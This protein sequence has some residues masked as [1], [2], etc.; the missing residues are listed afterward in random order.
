MSWSDVKGRIAANWQSGVTV[1]LVSI[2]L[3][4]SLAVASQATPVMGIIT[5][6]WAG[7]MAAIFGGSH[8]N[9][10]G[11]TGA[12]SGLLA[13]Y[14][15][16]HGMQM[17]PMLAIVTGVF[18]LIAYV[19]RLERFLV[20]VPASAI[21]GFTLGVAFIIGLNQLN[22]ALGLSGLPSH[23]TFIQNVLESL[24]HIGSASSVTVLVFLGFLAALFAFVK[25]LPKVPGAIVLAPIGILLGYASQTGMLPL[26][27]Q[28]LGARYPDMSAK[29]FALPTFSF[30][31]SLI[32]AA[33]GVAL[34][35]IL[36][37]MISAKIADG[38]TKTKYN[39]RK[40]M[41]GLGIANVASGLAGGIPATAALARTSLN[42]KTKATHST[43]AAI[44][45]VSIAL[46]SLILLT[47]FVY[48]PLAVIAAILVFVAARMVEGD[49]FK[50]FYR[51]DRKSF[52]IALLV[53][54]ITVY[55][56]PIVGLLLGTVVSLLLFMERLSR[57]QFDLVV[58][59]KDRG[60]VKKIVSEE[61]VPIL[62]GSSDTLV[63]S[64]KGQLAYIN[65][66]SHIT[67]FQQGLGGYERVLL[68]L[69]ELSFIDLDGVDAFNEIVEHIHGQGKVVMVSGAN[70][71]VHAL[72]EGSTLFRALEDNG[73]V[74]ERTTDAL[75][76][77]GYEIK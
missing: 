11:P 75:R 50:R 22:F 67:R 19:A 72:L 32:P 76:A 17:L 69:R 45:S 27:L 66:E 64:M 35:A 57:G 74:F 40:E 43:S 24:R 20:F 2:P 68:R 58:N 60:M 14:A 46:I 59:D 12:L 63:Y 70:P 39:K 3:S 51:Y 7:L 38:M 55:E 61:V 8:Y 31:T 53:A 65:A 54:S 25:W 9:I 36:E 13:A 49:V 37:T 28:T 34:I 47:Y 29:I 71:I 73:L 62:A 30:D 1:S 44:S 21:Q 6:I 77:V 5:A 15:L 41:L 26:G 4:V 33:L 18:V 52:I 56:D 10:V 23:E 48:I 16:T 42:V